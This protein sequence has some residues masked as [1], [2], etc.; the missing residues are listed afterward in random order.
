M[1]FPSDAIA[2]LESTSRPIFSVPPCHRVHTPRASTF[3]LPDHRTHG[4]NAPS[5]AVE[6]P[7]EGPRRDNISARLTFAWPWLPFRVKREILASEKS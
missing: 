2:P 3:P 1:A 6:R 7:S 4:V 5:P